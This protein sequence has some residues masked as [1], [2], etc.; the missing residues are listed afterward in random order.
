MTQWGRYAII[1]TAEESQSRGK[2]LL[3]LDDAPTAREIASELARRG[4][5]VAIEIRGSGPQSPRLTKTPP[6]AK[7]AT[8]SLV[9][10]PAAG[11]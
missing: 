10:F 3:L 4:L 11:A 5:H 7:G 6:R 9:R 1:D 2:I 8:I